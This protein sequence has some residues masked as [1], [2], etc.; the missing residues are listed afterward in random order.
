LVEILVT[1][2]IVGILSTIGIATYISFN[3]DQLLIQTAR[4][5]VEDLRLAQSLATNHQKPTTEE[6]TTLQ[7]YVFKVNGNSYDIYASCYPTSPADPV[8]S[9]SVPVN[10]SVTSFTQVEFK[11]LKQ[12]IILTPADQNTLT[13]SGFGGKQRVI[14][15][16]KAGDITIND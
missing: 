10:F 13:I 11:V 9:G 4:K 5:V 14:T 1:I 2:S 3:R 7:G 6:C 8:K 12:G 15:I 16:G